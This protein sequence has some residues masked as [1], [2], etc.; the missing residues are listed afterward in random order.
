M[1]FLSVRASLGLALFSIVA[2]TGCVPDMDTDESTV[3]A[4][5]LL[6]VIAEPAEAEPDQQVSYRALVV[7]QNGVRSDATLAWFYCNA[8]KPLSELG[9]VSTECL[10]RASGKLQMIGRGPTVDGA[11]PDQSCATFGPNLPQ[12]EEG[13]A[14]GRPVD[15]DETGGYS[16]PLMLG[17]NTGGADSLVL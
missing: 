3:V 17:L 4:P 9:P 10:A 11:L 5:R 14:P 15:A 8:P 6:A 7:D 2:G 13:Q 1:D 12:P 16:Q